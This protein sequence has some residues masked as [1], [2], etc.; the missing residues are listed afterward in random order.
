VAAADAGAGDVQ[1]QEVTVGLVVTELIV[2]L[3]VFNCLFA[4]RLHKNGRDS[5]MA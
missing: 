5:L 3:I 4:L 1:L 2:S